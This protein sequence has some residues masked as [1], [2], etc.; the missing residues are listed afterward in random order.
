M[1]ALGS[2]RRELPRVAKEIL[3][4]SAEER[5]V[6]LLDQTVRD[7]KLHDSFRLGFLEPLAAPRERAPLK[8]TVV[9]A[10]TDAR[11]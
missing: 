10:K 7:H 6:P 8:L 11:D 2:F 3:D 1:R 9:P 4:R 5:A